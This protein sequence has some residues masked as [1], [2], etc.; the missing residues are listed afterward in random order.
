[1]SLFRRK[2]RTSGL[3]VLVTL[4]AMLVSLTSLA[5]P[6]TD[7]KVVIEEPVAGGSYSGISNLRGY[8]VSPNG[9][10]WYN[11]NVYIDGEFAFHITS[12]GERADVRSAYPDYP[13][14][15]TGGFSMALNYKDLSPGEHEITVRG[16]DDAGSYNEASVTF[17]AERFNSTFIAEN[18]E[19]NLSTTDDIYLYDDQTYLIRGASVEGERWDFLL[20]W[21][22]ASQS[23]KA[24]GIVPFDSELSY[25][26]PDFYSEASDASADSSGGYSDG[27][28][29]DSSSTDSDDSSD[30]CPGPGYDCYYTGGSSDT[31]TGGTSDGSGGGSSSDADGGTSTNTGGSTSDSTSDTGDSS[32]SD[33]TSSSTGDGSSSSGADGDN[34]SGDSA[35]A[36]RFPNGINRRYID[37]SSNID[38]GSGGDSLGS[39]V[40]V[41]V[42]KGTVAVIG[43]TITSDDAQLGRISFGQISSWQSSLRLW[44]SETPDGDRVSEACSYNGYPEGSLRFSV[45]DSR[46]CRLSAGKYLVNMAACVQSAVFQRDWNCSLEGTMTDVNDNVLLIES[47]Y[48]SQ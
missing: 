14:S 33:T 17:I 46:E 29:G 34:G 36:I 16:Y 5:Y 2:R 30:G 24:E 6:N 3:R 45:D 13:D 43:L 38:I 23:F 48:Q 4:T 40:R 37:N 22:R 28:S 11:H 20:T 39:T 25:V 41:D 1:M 12:F 27:S 10:G 42:P 8:V 44:I 9:T 15:G 31:G 18:S 19:V 35:E 7:I 47:R 26:R 21:D 32:G